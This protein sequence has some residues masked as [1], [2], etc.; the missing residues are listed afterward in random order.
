MKTLDMLCSNLTFKFL[1][2]FSVIYLFQRILLLPVHVFTELLHPLNPYVAFVSRCCFRVLFVDIRERKHA[3]QKSDL[4]KV[5]W[6]W[7]E[8]LAEICT[9]A[10]VD[11]CMLNV[12]CGK[13]ILLWLSLCVPQSFFTL[14][15]SHDF[16]CLCLKA[17]Y[18][19]INRKERM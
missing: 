14:K 15:E 13:P 8:C 6:T 19:R 12:S 5:V 7:S 16:L 9:G 17:V 3:C 10:A 2:T 1:T 18:K 4:L 11:V